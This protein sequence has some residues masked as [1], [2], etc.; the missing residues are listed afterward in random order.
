MNYNLLNT[1]KQKTFA[2][3]LDNGDEVMESLQSF[4]KE[5]NLKAS[6]FSAIG[7]FRKT[8]LGFFDFSIKDY[9]KTEIDEQVEVLSIAGDISL[10]EDKIQVHAHTVPGK[11]DGTA[12]GGH[13]LKGFVHPT[14]EIIL[15]ESPG[16][17]ERKMDKDSHIPLIKI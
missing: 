1:D 8:T 16:Y 9:K 13:L 10:Y 11:S 5:Q 4:A 17:L 2:I 7:A 12:Y 15:T 3:I 14:L 6:Q